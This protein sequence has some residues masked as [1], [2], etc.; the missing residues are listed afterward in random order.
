MRLTKAAL[1]ALHVRQADRVRKLIED[2]AAKFIAG[3]LRYAA[4]QLR[5]TGTAVAS[6][7]YKP[8]ERDDKLKSAIGPAI[9]RAMLLGAVTE[10]GLRKSKTIKSSASDIL[11]EWGMEIED[12]ATE[13]PESMLQAIEEALADSFQRPYW[14]LIN[15]TTRAEIESQLRHGTEQG[16]SIRDM[17]SILENMADGYGRSRAFAIARTESTRALNAGHTLGIEQAETDSGLLLGKQWLSV[18]GSTSR[19]EHVEL[20]GTTVPTSG[21]FNLGGYLCD[22]PGDAS[23]PPEH[24]INC[25]CTVVSGELFVGD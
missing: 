21:Q 1:K 23:L 16:L 13:L 25:L 2:A 24:A 18:A 12:F 10:M 14:S 7:I 5:E 8:R 9:A 6:L 4:D 15:G 17:A 3:E 19:P 11:A 20:D 22:Y